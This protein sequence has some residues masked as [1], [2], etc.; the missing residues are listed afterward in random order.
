MRI[1]KERGVLGESQYCLNSG[2]LWKHSS[3]LCAHNAASIKQ[4]PGPSRREE[5]YK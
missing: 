1:L 3:R 2:R 4:Y 5:G